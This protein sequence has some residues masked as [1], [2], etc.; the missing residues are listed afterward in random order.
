MTTLH[1]EVPVA[2]QTASAMS[3]AHADLSTSM[4][5]MNTQVNSLQPDWLGN[6]ATEFYGEY[7]RFRNT[8]NQMLEALN[9][10]QQSLSKEITEWENMASK[11]A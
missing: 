11:L 9:L 6:S 7:D 1:M 8:M 5:T 3:K 10:L 2:R 4:Q